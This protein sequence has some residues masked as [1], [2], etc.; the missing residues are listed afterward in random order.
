MFN[1]ISSFGSAACPTFGSIA[2]SVADA[3]TF[4]AMAEQQPTA[5][6]DASASSAGAFGAR[7]FFCVQNYI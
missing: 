1:S 5:F 2:Q 4:N 3:P 6:G 7:K